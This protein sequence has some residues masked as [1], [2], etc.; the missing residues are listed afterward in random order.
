M[1][2]L[3]FGKRGTAGAFCQFSS[4]CSQAT[5][6]GKLAMDTK[7][8]TGSAFALAQA[9]LMGFAAMAREAVTPSA[10][11][12]TSVENTMGSINKG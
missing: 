4:H 1:L 2:I 6:H 3:Q 11:D 8:L 12:T 5:T 7:L 10:E 9:L